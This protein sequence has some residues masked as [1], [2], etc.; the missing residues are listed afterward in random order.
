[1]RCDVRG[2]L[3]GT[4]IRDALEQDINREEKFADDFRIIIH[5]DGDDTITSQLSSG[6]RRKRAYGQRMMRRGLQLYTTTVRRR[7]WSYY[8]RTRHDNCATQT[9][10]GRRRRGYR[11]SGCATLWAECSGPK[12]RPISAPR[13]R[14]RR[15]CGAKCACRLRVRAR[16][17]YNIIVCFIVTGCTYVIHAGK[18]SRSPL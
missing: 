5:N 12:G 13:A 9:F 2:R 7:P 3:R 6:V 14:R 16:V 1:M 15:H 10:S 18:D 11:G 4:E 17:Y 8:G